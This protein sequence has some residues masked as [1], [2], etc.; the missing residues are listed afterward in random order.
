KAAAAI[1]AQSSAKFRELVSDPPDAAAAAGLASRYANPD[2][3]RLQVSSA[4]KNVIFDFGPWKSRGVTR[5]NPDGTIAFITVDPGAP[6]AGF[7]AG[8]AGDKKQL[9]IRDGQHTYVYNEAP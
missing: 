8:S 3:G 4:G 9:T 5:K 7:V 2:L 1:Q 6:H